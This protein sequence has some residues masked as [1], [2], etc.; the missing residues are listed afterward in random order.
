MGFKAQ[1][2]D[3][4]CTECN[5]EGIYDIMIYNPLTKE[6]HLEEDI[7]EEYISGVDSYGNPYS[8]AKVS[9]ELFDI[10]FNK[11]L[12]R[13]GCIGGFFDEWEADVPVH[14]P[15]KNKVPKETVFKGIRGELS[16]EDLDKIV[17][18]D[19][20][21]AD[22][23]DFEAFISV[24]HKFL[25]GEISRDYYKHWVILVAWALSSHKFKE[26]SKRY[27]LYNSISDDFDG[28]SFG[29]L[30]VEKEQECYG[31]IASLKHNDHLL[32][33]IRKS[34]APPFFNENGIAV[35]I[36]LGYCNHYN[37]YHKICVAD[38]QNKIFK[39]DNIV[40]PFY[41]EH[42]NY[43]FVDEDEFDDLTNTYYEYFHDISMDIHEYIGER[44]FLDINGKPTN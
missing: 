44:P 21:K 4:I 11:L 8:S 17:Q 38:E 5:E 25:S 22:Y 1:D 16:V 36:C 24:M 20:E 39:I 33:N 41:Y 7:G 27:L 18:V 34:V 19:L 10:I 23:Y 40:N 3:F 35:Y 43:T 37:E 15:S 26:N 9:R 13:D 30:E 32:K 12:K 14:R 31:M 6:L 42:I 28:H 29:N 2:W